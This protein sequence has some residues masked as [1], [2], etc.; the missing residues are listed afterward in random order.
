MIEGMP[1]KRRRIHRA[2]S[3]TSG[4]DVLMPFSAD[5]FS[6]RRRRRFFATLAAVLAG[7]LAATWLYY[8]STNS[9]RARE[10][11]DS[12]QRLFRVGRYSQANLDFDRAIAIRPTYA[13]AYLFRARSARAVND[14]Q[15][16]ITDYSAS[17]RL[18]PNAQ[19]FVERGRA[20]IDSDNY[21]L[22]KAD[23]DSA[24]ALDAGLAPAYNLRGSAQR[25]LGDL[26][27]ALADFT[28]AVELGPDLDNHYQRGAILQMLG[29]P[30]EAIADFDEAIK[31]S[32][33]ATQVYYSRAA[34]KRALGDNEGAGR[35][36]AVGQSI[37]TR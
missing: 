11:F 37:D 5:D 7:G 12:G 32:P 9:M 25:G 33:Y 10:A 31:F 16:A 36:H 15:P 20:Y 19:A 23:G 28:K 29:R 34:A 17:L 27:G 26:Q 4:L 13:E 2:S 21:A 6:R 8:G 24:V 30:K 35:D 14:L 3:A 1:Y 22:A 18:Q